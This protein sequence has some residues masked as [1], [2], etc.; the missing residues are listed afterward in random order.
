MAWNEPGGGKQ[1]DPWREGGGGGPSPDLDA[2]L[3]RLRDAM[4]RLFGGGGS[5][6]GGLWLAVVAMVAVWCAW[7]SWQA[8]DAQRV[9]VVLRFG[10]FE[11]LM[12]EG[13]NFKWPRPIEYVISVENKVRSLS[14]DVRML[15]RDQN[16]VQVNFNV[17]YRVADPQKYLFAVRDSDETLKE[18][19]E[20]AL[21]QVIGA[22]DMDT[23]LSGGGATLVG[24]TQ[25]Q[26]QQTLDAYN[27]GITVSAVNFPNVSAPHEVKE[28]FDE[29][30]NA[31][32]NNKQY[33]NEANAYLS[34]VVPVARGEAARI[35]AEA[36]GYKAER[37]ARAEGDAQRFTLLAS[38]YKASPEVTRKRL[39]IET[40]QQVIGSNAKVIDLSGGKNILYL[41]VA[42]GKDAPTSVGP[43]VGALPEN[44]KEGR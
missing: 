30:N 2:L 24:D 12:T 44:G 39:Y 37:I 20:S 32:E 21:R 26:L 29:V 13:F 25:K 38:Q 36:E 11:R 16:I 10:K 19:A 7:D 5:G 6:G 31:N 23:T 18:A 17:Q 1:R 8:I 28:A 42:P 43:P 14:D 33:V 34:R 3:K 27:A 9:G 22:N 35:R 41:P 40:M 4:G 15:T